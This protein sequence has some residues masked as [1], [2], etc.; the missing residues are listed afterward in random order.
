[1]RDFILDLDRLDPNDAC[2]YG[3]TTSGAVALGDWCCVERSELK[4]LATEF[5]RCIEALRSAR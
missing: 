1:M 4:Q 5:H 3:F 2:R